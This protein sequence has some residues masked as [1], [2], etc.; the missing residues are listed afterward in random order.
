M[1]FINPEDYEIK[2][3]SLDE[4]LV[5]NEK[6]LSKEASE[7]LVTTAGDGLLIEVDGYET[8]SVN[9]HNLCRENLVDSGKF[10]LINT[11]SMP[12]TVTGFTVSEPERFSL[13]DHEKYRNFTIYTQ[14]VVGEL[15]LTI[16][17]RK[18]KTINTFF[19]PK[20]EELEYGKEGTILNRNGDQFGAKV[21]IYPG[22]KISNCES[23]DICDASLTLTGEFL[24]ERDY[25]N[26][27]ALKNKHNF[28]IPGELPGSFD[29]N[30]EGVPDPTNDLIICPVLDDEYSYTINFTSDND[31]SATAQAW[32]RVDENGKWETKIEVTQAFN[33][34]FQLTDWQI[35]HSK[36]E[37]GNTS[38]WIIVPDGENNTSDYP[39]VFAQG[40]DDETN[41]YS[42]HEYQDTS[43][44]K[45][46]L[47]VKPDGFLDLV[48]GNLPDTQQPDC[49]PL[50]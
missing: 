5:I 50:A 28:E 43:T 8:R 6:Y 18:K 3:S 4:A 42:I 11:C 33:D 41:Y 38:A 31:E 1:T 20:Y 37:A 40:T 10:T 47:T 23:N 48:D 22:F 25:K 32:F 16:E 29:P 21:E 15:P 30:M 27:E 44:S 34:L 9:C 36:A 39:I 7:T 45:E 13:F 2:F 24:C 46:D 49:I 35:G 12:I 19:H 26:L 17:P 14:E